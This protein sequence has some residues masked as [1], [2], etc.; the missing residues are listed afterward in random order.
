VFHDALD[1]DQYG[2]VCN[3]IGNDIRNYTQGEFAR[4]ANGEDTQEDC[5]GI[6]RK[7]SRLFL[8][9]IPSMPEI[10][11]VPAL[12]SVLGDVMP[13]NLIGCMA[14]SL[15]NITNLG[16]FPG[17]EAPT[18]EEAETFFEGFTLCEPG[19]E[20][21]ESDTTS[22]IEPWKIIAITI[23]SAALFACVRGGFVLWRRGHEEDHEPEEFP[24]NEDVERPS[25]GY[26]DVRGSEFSVVATE[27]DGIFNSFVN[28]GRMVTDEEIRLTQGGEDFTEEDYVSSTWGTGTTSNPSAG[29]LGGRGSGGIGENQL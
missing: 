2:E 22:N 4:I 29:R 3:L 12:P 17:I 1:P 25:Q 27:L 21:P 10:P 16:N 28:D 6:F 5:T 18:L 11:S 7:I 26:M 19:V 24:L 15:V 20:T 14:A 8:D 23:A 13:Q 9:T